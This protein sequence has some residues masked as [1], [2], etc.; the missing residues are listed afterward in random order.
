MNVTKLPKDKYDYVSLSLGEVL[1][2]DDFVE[3]SSKI[4]GKPGREEKVFYK[5]HIS[6]PIYI[7]GC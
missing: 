2:R 4:I 5:K 3:V 1:N 7:Y 6:K